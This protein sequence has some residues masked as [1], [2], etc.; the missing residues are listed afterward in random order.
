[1]LANSLFFF[2]YCIYLALPTR[3]GSPQQ[4]V[5]IIVG[6]YYLT[7]Q[8]RQLSMWEETGVPRENPQLP[9]SMLGS[10]IEKVLT[11]I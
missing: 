8:G 10:S 1:M 2:I 7:H 5:Q 11:E 3:A 6:P 4:H 9:A